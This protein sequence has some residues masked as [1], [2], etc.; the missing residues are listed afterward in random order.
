MRVDALLE[1]DLDQLSKLADLLCGG[2]FTLMKFTTNWKC[3]FGTPTR[4]EIMLAPSFDKIQ[5][6][7]RACIG[8]VRYMPPSPSTPWTPCEKGEGPKK[9]DEPFL[10]TIKYDASNKVT[11]SVM[12]WNGQEWFFANGTKSCVTVL[13]YRDLPDAW[14]GTV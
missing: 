8:A 13:A 7:I 4:Q 14:E 6:A 5:D 11:T 3:V 1:R 12:H 9:V 2:H 10:V